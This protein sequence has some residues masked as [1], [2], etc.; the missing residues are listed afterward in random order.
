MNEDKET[1]IIKI[2]KKY[3]DRFQY[4]SDINIESELLPQQ[5]IYNT[6]KPVINELINSA[7][8]KPHRIVLMNIKKY[9]KDFG[10]NHKELTYGGFYSFLKRS[11]IIRDKKT[12]TTEEEHKKIELEQL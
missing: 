4:L 9:T 6:L 11:K 8:I 12:E 5:T 2:I 7:E 10:I 3:S 1:Q